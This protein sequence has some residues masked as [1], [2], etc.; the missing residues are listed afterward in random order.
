MT[1]TTILGLWRV[2]TDSHLMLYRILI[3]DIV[4]A[5]SDQSTLEEVTHIY[6][7]SEKADWL[8]T[9]LPLPSSDV[10]SGSM[11]LRS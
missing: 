11:D 6:F 4:S 10:V 2:V 3:H 7:T 9:T 8:D 1:T 5:L